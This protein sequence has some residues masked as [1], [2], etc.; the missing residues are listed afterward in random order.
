MSATRLFKNIKKS[1]EDCSFLIGEII[2]RG[3][4]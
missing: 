3:Q 2:R 4:L 1:F